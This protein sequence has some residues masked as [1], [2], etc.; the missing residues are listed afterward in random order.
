MN[1]KPIK[2]TD[3]VLAE[4]VANIESK[5]VG[6]LNIRN[7]MSLIRGATCPQCSGNI[8]AFRDELSVK[9]YKISGLCQHCQDDFFGAPDSSGRDQGEDNG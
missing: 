4:A 8:I 5:P 3:D 2:L 9:E 1:E 7:F 6:Q